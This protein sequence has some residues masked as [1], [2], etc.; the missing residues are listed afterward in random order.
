MLANIY[1]TEFDFEVNELAKGLGGLYMR[2]SD[3]FIFIVPTT[4]ELFLD[5]LSRIGAI[6]KSIP[7]VRIHPDKTCA[8]RYDGERVANTGIGKGATTKAVRHIDYLGFSFDGAC[9]RLR[10]RTVGRYYRRMYRRVKQL[11]G[12]GSRPSKRR[13]DSLYIDFS[14]WGRLPGRNAA[15]KRRVGKEK[16]RGN[17][18]TYAHRAKRS[19]P[20]DDI[21]IDF[22]RHKL[23]IRKRSNELLR[24]G[25]S[26]R[27]ACRDDERP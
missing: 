24:E 15:V 26:L 19:F 25:L 10:Q 3:D 18:L 16:T 17:F 9:V 8:Y 23:K 2:Y 13:V 20:D 7:S 4:R 1:M 11:Y 12:N 21:L 5:A 22:R 6:A 27:A 14:D